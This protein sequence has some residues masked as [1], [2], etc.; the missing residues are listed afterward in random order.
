[1]P[2][3]KADLDYARLAQYLD[4]LAYPVRLELLHKLQMPHTVGEIRVTPH[5]NTK[6][7]SQD[8]PLARQTVQGHL[9]KL[10]AAGLVKT[11]EV[12]QGGKDVP[13]Y[14]VD[15]AQLYAL[16]EDM[17][18]LSVLYAGPAVGTE[19][20]GTVAS[21][22]EPQTVDGPR[23]VLVHGVYEGK[24]FPLDGSTRDGDR[25]VIGRA[26]DA[27]ISLDY[28]RFVSGKNSIITREDGVFSIED[29]ADN[30]NGTSINWETMPEGSTR[31][32]NNG[33]IIGVGRSLLSFVES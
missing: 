33:D 25:W 30:K 11:L 17:R 28:D 18:R 16:I 2:R 26:D 13:A 31:E 12:E 29:L 20:T 9:D 10:M 8:R 6:D 27:S 4:A 7:G 32:L 3:R 19:E 14:R 1:M 24:H 5:R 22:P 15:P 23:L 21:N